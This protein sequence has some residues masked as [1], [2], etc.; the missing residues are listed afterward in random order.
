[1][2]ASHARCLKDPLVEW[3][4]LAGMASVEHPPF[5]L[6]SSGHIK[7][8]SPRSGFSSALHSAGSS[9]WDPPTAPGSILD[10]LK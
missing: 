3:D 9:A 10:V 5:F 7:G 6:L 1:M 4:K 2:H 8:S